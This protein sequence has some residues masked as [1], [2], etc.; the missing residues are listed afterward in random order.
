MQEFS[1][2]SKRGAD[3]SFTKIFCHRALDHAHALN[4]SAPQIRVPLTISASISSLVTGAPGFQVNRAGKST[5]MRISPHFKKMI[6]PRSI[7]FMSADRFTVGTMTN[8]KRLRFDSRVASKQTSAF[9]HFINNSRCVGVMTFGMSLLVG[10]GL[11]QTTNPAST[12]TLASRES[13][14][15]PDFKP[16]PDGQVG[17]RGGWTGRFP[18]ATPP[19]EWSR[20]VKGLTSEIKYQ[21]GKPSR[22]PGGDSFPLEYFTIKEWLVIGP[23]AADDPAQN[24][25]KDFLGGEDKVEPDKDA[26]AGGSTWK[27][28]RAGTGTQSRHC[29]NEGTV[30]D[31][32]VDFVY[33]FGNLPESGAP[34][35]L[36]VPLNNKVAYAHT[37]FHSPS[38]GQVL[39]RLNYAT[40]AIKVFV[41]G[42]VVAVKRGEP[43]KITLAK[44][45]N[46][47]LVKA[48]SGEATAPEG[49]NAW[50]S[51][52]RFAV[53]LEP[54]PPVSYETRNIAWMTRM[55]GRSM[56]QPIIVGERVYVGSG[57]T[58]LLCLDKRSGKI[59]WLRSNT[60][61]D[62]MTAEERA[63]IPQVKEQVEPLM[64]RLGAL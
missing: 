61:Y 9:S 10:S 45:W 43:V 28:L 44:G 34:K 49:Q 46:R 26:E 52:W 16:G 35:S 58:D 17:W 4:S 59:L 24:I 36:E 13:L 63:A 12:H 23:F 51:R 53:Y 60:P 57:L 20:R 41:N 1:Q 42:Q 29:H 7:D 8:D 22:E 11:G 30:G 62:A 40:A 50:V 54:V 64:A 6:C 39:L 38:G 25:E 47:L 55:T 32:N 18:G 27:H 3:K 37:Y 31:L 5:L 56:S 19:M 2:R 33:V 15:S 48:A 21:A 14:G